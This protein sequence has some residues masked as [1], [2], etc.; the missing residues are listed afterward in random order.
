MRGEADQITL[1]AI[2]CSKVSCDIGKNHPVDEICLQ[3][4]FFK[5]GSKLSQYLALKV[6]ILRKRITIEAASVQ[7]WPGAFKRSRWII[8]LS[9]RIKIELTSIRSFANLPELKFQVGERRWRWL[10]STLSAVKVVQC[11]EMVTL[12]SGN[13]SKL[14]VRYAGRRIDCNC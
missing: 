6:L 10:E 9:L 4:L 1:P 11:T 7:Q 13:D 8:T 14:V 2:P 3:G 5:P 12:A